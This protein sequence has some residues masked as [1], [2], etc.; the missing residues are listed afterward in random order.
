[1]KH[2][3]VLT[4]VFAA[5]LLIIGCGGDSSSGSAKTHCVENAF[6]CIDKTLQKCEDSSW[7]T[8]EKCTG[9]CN[10]ELGKCENGNSDN[11]SENSGDN[12]DDYSGN[13][14]NDTEDNSGNNSGDNASCDDTEGKNCDTDKTCG[15][16]M[17]CV[18]GICQKGC[19][20]DSD[21]GIVGTNCNKKLARCVNIYASR[22]ACNEENCPTGCCYADKGLT[23]LKC[24]KTPNPETCGLCNQNAIFSPMDQKCV[25][26]VC[27]TTSDNCPAIN[28]ESTNPPSYC[29]ECRVGE[30]LCSTTSSKAG[31]SAAALI[32]MN[33]CTPS[34]RKCD[35]KTDKCCS[36][37]PCIEGYCY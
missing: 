34:G 24:A 27:S 17:I 37:M 20:S 12:Q 19:T 15:A 9:K 16:C 18:S 3:P 35:G 10:N 5:M 29:Y 14:E 13:S 32:N 7:T 11:N 26:A 21:C 23:G 30:L 25:N 22:G 4:A 1:M 31:C 28:S 8:V 36:G 6:R 2:F 33:E